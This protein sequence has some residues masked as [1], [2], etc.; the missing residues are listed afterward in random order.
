MIM[1][2]QKA[3]QSAMT[4]HHPST[5]HSSLEV[6]GIHRENVAIEITSAEAPAY[7]RHSSAARRA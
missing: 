2:G 3:A 6:G 4:M 1:I 5:G 7:E